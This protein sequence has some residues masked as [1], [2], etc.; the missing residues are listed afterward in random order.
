MSTGG[1]KSEAVGTVDEVLSSGA[2]IL[3]KFWRKFAGKPKA[4][5]SGIDSAV[6]ATDL[7]KFLQQLLDQAARE[8]LNLEGS[9]SD[10]KSQI[11]GKLSVNDFDGAEP[12]LI[13][14]AS[15]LKS[16]IAHK[17]DWLKVDGEFKLAQ[18]AIEQ[19]FSTWKAP[20]T[21]GNGSLKYYADDIVSRLSKQDFAGASSQFLELK[22]WAVSPQDL[23]G[24]YPDRDL[25]VA[26][27]GT[28]STAKQN[29]NALATHS[30]PEHGELAG[31]LNSIEEKASVA[32]KDFKT[33]ASQLPDLAKQIQTLVDLYPARGQWETFKKPFARAR[34]WITDLVGWQIPE[35]SGWETQINTIEQNATDKAGKYLDAVNAFQSLEPTIDLAH[36][37]WS[38]QQAVARQVNPLLQQQ[39]SN[40]GQLRASMA[41]ATELGSDRKYAEGMQVLER[42]KGLVQASLVSNADLGQLATNVA[43]LRTKAETALSGIEVKLR[44]KNNDGANRVADVIKELITKLPTDLETKLREMDDETEESAMGGRKTAVKTA[45]QEWLNFLAT[46][47]QSLDACAVNPFKQAFDLPVAMTATIK[48]VLQQVA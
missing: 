14:L 23:L 29:L 20:E 26:L 3:R 10:R 17:Q 27:A 12:L 19:L 5:T 34:R 18:T 48:T 47:K 11:E 32:T 24:L 16:A 42:L 44:E 41:L 43:A 15:Q 46:N 37:F 36:R 39:P 6:R 38:K 25:W 13:E 35:A 40:A 9:L 28:L 45:A 30:A 8:S 7:S 22:K 2:A 33:A 31:K 1:K 21:R 4:P